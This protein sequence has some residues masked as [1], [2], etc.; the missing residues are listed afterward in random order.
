[1]WPMQ[2]R[3]FLQLGLSK[4]ILE[5]SLGGMHFFQERSNVSSIASEAFDE[6]DLNED[7][8]KIKEIYRKLK[9]V[10]F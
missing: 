2:V 8:L 10:Q 9:K 1:M 4:R 5:L 6:C 7:E 3:P